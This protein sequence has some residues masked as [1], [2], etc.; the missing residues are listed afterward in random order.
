L[1]SVKRL[2]KLFNKKNVLFFLYFFYCNGA[3][4][5][6][7]SFHEYTID[8]IF[9]GQEIQRSYSIRFPQNQTENSYPVVFFFHGAGGNSSMFLRNDIFQLIDQNEFI[10]VFLDGHTK[11]D[12]RCCFWNVNNDPSPD[13]VEFFELVYSFLETQ[14]IFNLNYSYGIGTSNGASMVN[15]LGKEADFF[16]AIA[17]IVSQQLVYIGQISPTRPMS[18]FQ[19]IGEN[20]TTIPPAGGLIWGSLNFLSAEESAENW[21]NYFGCSLT[22]KT[23]LI[24]WGSRQVQENIYSNCLEGREVRHH[25]VEDVGHTINL[26]GESLYQIIWNFFSSQQQIVQKNTENKIPMVGAPGILFLAMIMLTL[27]KIS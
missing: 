20:D 18:I 15:K 24:T 14:E 10:G 7:L 5:Q 3:F 8:Q 21:A 11:N 19:V 6:N 25:V 13:D 1:K 23:S 16:S 9:N 26:E 2:L 17:P 27:G 22:E 12:G 4:S